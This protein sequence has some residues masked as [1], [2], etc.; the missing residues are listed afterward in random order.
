MHQKC[1]KSATWRLQEAPKTAP[2]RPKADF[3]S[4]LAA[5]LGPSWASFSAQDGLQ[6]PR[7]PPKGLLRNVLGRLGCVLGPLGGQEPTRASLGAVLAWFSSIFGRLFAWFLV[8]KLSFLFFQLGTSNLQ[9]SKVIIWEK[10]K[11]LHREIFRITPFLGIS[12]SRARCGRCR[13]HFDIV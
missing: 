9:S 11:T 5:N 1:V 8:E 10:M 7:T 3:A 6:A 2:G 12:R 13:R 4:V